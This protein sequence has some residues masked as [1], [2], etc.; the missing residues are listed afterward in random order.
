[1]EPFSLNKSSYI[2]LYKQL[3]DQFV[4]QIRSGELVTGTRM[5]S[6]REIAEGYQV[7]RTT[8]R[9]AIDELVNQS[10]VYR[11]QGKGTFVAN[12]GMRDLMGFASFT[13]HM[14][15]LGRKPSSKIIKLAVQVPSPA[16]R[17]TLHLAEEEMIVLLKRVRLADDKPIAIQKSYI[18][19]KL[20][21]GLVE[22]DLTNQ[23]LFQ[24]LKT[25]YYIFPAW[26]EANVEASLLRDDNAAL[27]NVDA[28]SPGLIV[29]G[30]TYTDTFQ[31]VEYVQTVYPGG[32]TLHIG[33][34][35]MTD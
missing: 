28:H 24:I 3:V 12:P 5:P 22:I 15:S 19:E 1:M 20:V 23:S 35:K 26:S 30:L 21:P 34:Q 8:A 9:Q 13:N 16:L 31:V 18:P 10:L 17:E 2:P 6:E 33:R 11:E 27:L 25:T 7:S 4:S 29:N 32:L 14:L